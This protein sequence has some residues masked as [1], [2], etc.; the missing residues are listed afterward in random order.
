[1]LFFRTLFAFGV[2]RREGSEKVAGLDVPNSN[3]VAFIVWREILGTLLGTLG[4]DNGIMRPGDKVIF[5]WRE[6]NEPDEGVGE[7]LNSRP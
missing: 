6:V 5:V 4:D 1:M 3:V 7:T 2:Y